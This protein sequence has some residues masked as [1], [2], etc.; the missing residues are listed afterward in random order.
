MKKSVVSLLV[1]LL[2]VSVVAACAGKENEAVTNNV[3]QQSNGAGDKEGGQ[4]NAAALDDGTERLTLTFMPES[5][6]GGKWREDHPTIQYLNEKF[7]VDLKL[8]WTDG[9]TYN[10][11]LN[12]MAASGSLPDLYRVPADNYGKWQNEEVFTDLAPYLE[13]YPNLAQAYPEYQWEMMNPDGKIYGIPLWEVE[14]RDSYQVRADWI[15]SVGLTMPDEATFNLDEF[16][17]I[18][19][20]FALNDPDQN[21]KKDT[22]GFATDNTLSTNTGQLRA[23]F[24]LANGWKLVNDQL[25]PQFVQSQEQQDFLAYLRNMYEEGII[26]KDFLSRSNANV[27]ELYQAGKT[28]LYHHHPMAMLADNV[29]LKE[30]DADAELVQLAPPIGPSGLRGNPAGLI[31]DRKV[32]INGTIDPK[33]Q[34]RILKILDW[35]VTDEGTDIMRSG[36]EGVH[37]T[38]EADGTYKATE[39]IETDLPRILNNWFFKRADANLNVFRWT[40]PQEAEFVAKYNENNALYPWRNDSGGLTIYSDTY[41]SKWKDLE[42]KFIEAQL[43]I[44]IGQEPVDSIDQAIEAWKA[45]GGDQIIQEVNDAYAKQKGK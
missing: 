6:S 3:E 29:K 7:N 32:V 38:K 14:V 27:Y 19:K 23:A 44:V 45:G 21:G 8:M 11:K 4:D 35:W 43:K 36:I 39:L 22:I 28:G 20:A 24:G 12:V 33:K 42:V 25:I 34:Q 26:D 5:W 1:L 40:D 17:E 18:V 9:P 30:Y 31:G 37:Y 15:R 10:D 41:A 13:Q 2:I 16:Y